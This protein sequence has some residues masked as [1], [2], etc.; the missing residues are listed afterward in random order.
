MSA[1]TS[2]IARW[3]RPWFIQHFGIIIT[4]LITNGVRCSF[5]SYNFKGNKIALPFIEPCIWG[6][7]ISMSNSLTYWRAF[8]WITLPFISTCLSLTCLNYF[9]KAASRSLCCPVQIHHLFRVCWGAV[10]CSY[11]HYRIFLPHGDSVLWYTI[12]SCHCVVFIPFSRSIIVLYLSQIERNLWALC[13][14]VDIFVI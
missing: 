9:S 8:S 13:F 10:I 6:L 3:W 1:W 7:E 4:V 11:N 5:S 14:D 2:L 12:L